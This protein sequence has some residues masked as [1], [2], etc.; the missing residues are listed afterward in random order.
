MAPMNDGQGKTRMR[1]VKGTSQGLLLD[2][3][4]RKPTVKGTQSN[5]RLQIKDEM[6]LRKSYFFFRCILSVAYHKL[7]LFNLHHLD[8]VLKR[9][10]LLGSIHLLHHHTVMVRRHQA[11]GII[12]VKV[13]LSHHK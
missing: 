13:T 8:K 5:Y 12:K 2:I 9:V 3:Q 7:A 11:R 6:M 1:G 4:K 10:L